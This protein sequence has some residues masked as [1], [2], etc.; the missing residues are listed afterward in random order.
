M[1]VTAEGV[2]RVSKPLEHTTI[3]KGAILKPDVVASDY[4][5]RLRCFVYRRGTDCYVAECVD[6]D[7]SAEGT[8]DKEAICGLQDAMR[9]YLKVVFDGQEQPDTRG[10]IMRPSPLSHRVR[11]RLESMKDVFRAVFTDRRKRTGAKFYSVP[12][13]D[14]CLSR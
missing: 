13:H 4:V 2:R 10:L 14:H 6:L 5:I 7:I 3:L 12:S 11:Y 9:G 8:T 1:G